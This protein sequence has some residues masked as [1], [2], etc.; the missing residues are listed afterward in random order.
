MAELM[1]RVRHLPIREISHDKITRIKHDMDELG[2]RAESFRLA[3]HF[4]RGAGE[5]CMAYY[6]IL[7][8]K[9]AYLTEMARL[10]VNVPPGF[11]LTSRA[12]NMFFSD[13]RALCDRTQE[14][15]W[16]SIERLEEISGCVLGSSD[17]PLLLAVRAGS[18]VSMP[19]M[20]DTILNV[21]FNHETAEGLVRI[22]GNPLF[23]YECYYR[24]ILKY[25]ASVLGLVFGEEDLRGE[26]A[27]ACSS[28]D[29]MQ[30]A[31]EHLLALA[32]AA[33]KPFPE[34][35]REQ[36]LG[37]LKA[38]FASW[39]SESAI[40]Y[41]QIFNVPHQ[42]GTAATIQQMVFGNLGKHSCSGVAF[43]RSPLTGERRLFGEYLPCSQGETLACGQGKPLPLSAGESDRFS[44]LSLETRFPDLYWELDGVARQIELHLGD[45]QDI[46]F[47]VE[48]NRLYV[49]Q[50]RPAKRTHRAALKVA[51]DLVS[52]GI[53]D[54]GQAVARL[55]ETGLRELLLPI[56]DTSESKR[57]MAKGNP[58]SPGVA[59]GKLAFT[60]RDAVRRAQA[61]EDV[62]FVADRTT[63]NDIGGIAA[64]RGVLTRE[65]G[66]TSHAAINSRRMAKP[67]V[68]G[69]GP[70]E[71]D[72]EAE[73]LRVDAFEL[74][75]ED[76]IS[77]DGYTG[78]VFCG[79]VKII[80]PEYPRTGSDRDSF[81]LVRYM[82]TYLEWKREALSPSRSG[83]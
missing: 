23:A 4:Q 71:V 22:S 27:L 40:A 80:E 75:P 73:I 51:V 65:G 47:T 70:I 31:V 38:V 8:E 10:G 69:C 29:G 14:V 34:D 33:G 52:E 30:Q 7:G 35:P 43:S 25:S 46:E 16:R 20:M 74:G 24:L 68:S 26:E 13:G 41:R 48:S 58:A 2:K 82:D 62:I 77:I 12:C 76:T 83:P 45:M 55:D 44:R 36:L 72:K 78:E 5:G 17:R 57:L 19:G 66:M 18:C 3:Y 67:C 32:E 49:L 79:A 60:R 42:F 54:R 61:G 53:I 50:T 28:P 15:L 1:E 11:I 37:A 59:C 9:G 39:Q 63:P 21:G 56:F 64:S 6:S 81:D